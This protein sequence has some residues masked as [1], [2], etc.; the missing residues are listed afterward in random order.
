MSQSGEL[1]CSDLNILA[2]GDQRDPQEQQDQ[3]IQEILHECVICRSRTIL[4]LPDDPN[5]S[6]LCAECVLHSRNAHGS[7]H[8]SVGHTNFVQNTTM[9]HLR[10]LANY[11]WF[12]NESGAPSRLIDNIR[13]RG[14]QWSPYVTP[15]N[16]EETKEY[17]NLQR[18]FISFKI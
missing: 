11:I 18:L 9:K 3:R 2:D 7:Y 13:E 17:A 16:E 6:T 14:R 12:A 4:K 15:A 5:V 1:K 8:N 10:S